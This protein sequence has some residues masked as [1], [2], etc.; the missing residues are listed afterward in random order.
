MKFKHI[1]RAY[2][3]R[4]IVGKD[5]FPDVVLRISTIFANMISEEGG[6]NIAVSGDIRIST[7][8]FIH[9]II[10]GIMAAGLDVYLTHP[11]PMPVFCHFVWR[12]KY[13]HGGAYV[14][15][16]H[17]PPQYNGIRFRRG[18]GTGFTKE[19]IEIERRFFAD[20]IKFAEWHQSGELKII[21]NRKAITE[22][23]EFVKAKIPEPSRKISVVID[24]RCGAANLVSP[25]L[26]ASF[27]HKVIAI[28]SVIDGTFPIGLPDPL[29]GDVSQIRSLVAE[30]KIPG[31]SYDGDGDRA[32]FFD[33]KGRMV[34][35]EIIALFIAEN[36]L[37]ANDKLVYNTMCSSILK[38]KAEEMGFRTIECRVGDTFTAEAVKMHNAKLGVE[39]SYHFFLPIYGFYYVES[40]MVSA[41]VVNLLANS[42]KTLADIYDHY[43]PIHTIRLN[44]EVDEEVKFKVV[45][46]FKEWALSKYSDVSTIDG[47]KIYLENGSFL[48]RPSNTEPLIR[49]VA[50]GESR[51]IAEEVLRKFT[52]KLRE[53]ISGFSK[54]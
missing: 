24:G 40:I 1:F 45:E 20:M 18:D 19:N 43:G 48:A 15:A 22:Y 26:F 33:E 52:K 30:A 41:L 13:I 44:I 4:G 49:I 16:S 37:K 36:L 9:A 6:K 8:S 25:K 42:G 2:D 14:T 54:G 10:S 38:K 39:E 12:R 34:P 11:L 35:A 23:I 32:A 51:S 46:K 27:G 28:N 31:V 53:I 7:P 50:D 47:V 29:H 17:N 21:P 3:I 5:I